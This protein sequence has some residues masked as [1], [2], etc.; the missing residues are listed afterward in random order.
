MG[1]HVVRLL[2]ERGDEVTVLGRNV[3]PE[4]EAMGA[5]SL[6]ADICDGPSMQAHFQ[7]MD[8]VYHVA[9]LA[10]IWGEWKSFYEINVTGTE[11]VIEACRH[12]RVPKLIYTSSPSV[13]FDGNSQRGVNEDVPYPS[14]FLAH[15]PHTK[16]LAEQRVLAANDEFLHTVSLRPHLIWGPGD[17]HLIP[18]VIVRARLGQLAQVGDGEN[19]VDIIYVENAARAHLQAAAALGPQGSSNGRAYFLGQ[20]KPVKLWEFIAEVLDRAQVP[21]V[22][23]KLPFSVAYGLGAAMEV[24][25]R[26]LGRTQEPRM[27]R[28]LACQ[29]AKDHFY[30]I[31]RA[32]RD[33]G[34]QATVSVSE[35]LDRLFA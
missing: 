1:Q 7:G 18:R 4:V 2:R 3:Y 10:D 32:R 30:D 9:A 26:T 28:F 35:G 15:Y 6:R 12:H 14:T 25:Y 20:E 24:A 8:E 23:R 33:F 11:N 5:R 19:E 34:Y 22:K 21:Q 13:V 17:R 27:T 31:S 29:L 16:K